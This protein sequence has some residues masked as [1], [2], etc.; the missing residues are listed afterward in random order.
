[1]RC[2]WYRATFS[3]D[4]LFLRCSLFMM[5]YIYLLN[6]MCFV[7][8]FNLQS[9]AVGYRLQPKQFTY[10]ANDVILY[11]LGSKS[12][13]LSLPFFGLF[14]SVSF[15]QYLCSCLSIHH[16]FQPCSLLF[17]PYLIPLLSMFLHPPSHST[18]F[19]YLSHSSLLSHFVITNSVFLHHPVTSTWFR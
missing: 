5:G 13:F 18:F 11:A 19:L 16:L 7:L 1:M 15:P 10:T 2:L 3:C 17:S 14:I 6:V 4:I 8:F 12:F 9:R